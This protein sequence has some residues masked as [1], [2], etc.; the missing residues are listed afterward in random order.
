MVEELHWKVIDYLTENYNTI[1][2]GKLSSKE[3]SKK[4]ES[5][6]NNMT[7]IVAQRMRFYK[8]QKRLEYKCNCKKINYKLID[9]KYTSKMCSNCGNI[10]HKLKDNKI[11]E[12]KKCKIKI[13]R[14]CN[15]SRG[16]T[17]KGI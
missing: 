14:D 4:E 17:I 13:D 5:I 6:L 11:Y 15:G 9:E 3:I 2:L 8:F 12:C 10:D 16:I 1:L 7:K